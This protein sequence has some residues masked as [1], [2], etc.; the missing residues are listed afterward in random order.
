MAGAKHKS[1]L[2]LIVGR[3]TILISAIV[4]VAGMSICQAQ[5][6]KVFLLAGQSNMVGW[7][8]NSNLPQELQQPR[9]DIQIYW[10]GVWTYLRP[11]LGGSSS[12][13]GPEITFCRD[14]VDVQ[15]GEDI[16]FV[17]YAVSGTSL[18]NDWQPTYGVQY[19]NFMNTID[20]ALLSVS[21]PEIVGMIWMQGE[22]DA[23]PSQSTLEHAQ[24]YQQ[25]LTN[26]I[27]SV[28]ADL[29]I[30]DLPFV[31]GRISQSPVWTWRDIVR[32][33]Q[34][35]VSQ[36]VPNTALVDTD[37]LPLLTDNMH[38]TASGM[39]TLGT[40]FADAANAMTLPSTN[41]FS[42]S[43][44]GAVLSWR[45]AIPDGNNRVLVVG[46][47]GEDDD[48]CDLA[49]NS[50]KY[51]GTTMNGVPG[52]SQLVFSD[53]R[54]VITQL[55]Y[56]LENDLPAA[57]DYKLDINF[58]ANVNKRCGGAV[59]L[60]GVDQEPPQAVATSSTQDANSIST[61]ITIQT[62]GA[63]IVDVV[64]CSSE[65]VFTADS[66]QI[67]EFN[68]DGNNIAIAGSI[69]PVSLAGSVTVSWDINDSNCAIAHSTA[70]F[71]ASLNT[72]SGHIHG[73]DDAPIEGVTVTLDVG[74][75]SDTTDPNGHYEVPVVHNWSGTIA[76]VKDGYLFGPSKR[77]YSNVATDLSGQNYKDISIYDLDTDGLIGL[78][79]VEIMYENWLRVGP[80]I[81]GD[82]YK[83]EDNTVNFLDFADFADVWQED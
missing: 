34:V 58:S 35:N 27:Q 17:K 67:T 12:Y 65:G 3:M 45:Y 9:P 74:G 20:N 11:G 76:P 19:I 82:F 70:A 18:W 66:S 6:T 83:D 50:V 64:G 28:R 37:D 15:P 42:S 23:W 30:P 49:I 71:A 61:D 48:P 32:Q 62:D 69:K 72:I 53:G 55:F 56:L 47:C 39:V 80:D 60:S 2:Y 26:F 29:G 40:R 54:Y 4:L 75:N 25:N 1:V 46:V 21:E 51:N 73:P 16:V 31:I 33:A 63:W 38:Y 79:D 22:S 43:S 44:E 13:F 81:P 8:S 59:T 78:G 68:I 36:T 41:C 24:E 52:S 5:T 14:I 7:S 57:D 10:G 77:T